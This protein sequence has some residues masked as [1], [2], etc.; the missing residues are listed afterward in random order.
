[1]CDLLLTYSSK[2]EIRL[3]LLVSDNFFFLNT[4]WKRIVPVGDSKINKPWCVHV[5]QIPCVSLEPSLYR[6][7]VERFLLIFLQSNNE[8]HILYSVLRHKSLCWMWKLQQFG[9]GFFCVLGWGFWC[10]GFLSSSHK[11]FVI[12]VGNTE[13][14]PGIPGEKIKTVLAFLILKFASQNKIP[15]EPNLLG[16]LDLWVWICLWYS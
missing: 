5:E 16:C 13:F 15:T 10:V 3:R 4:S 8:L 14:R 1:M 11:G 7:S 6:F 2:W 12:Y 9:L